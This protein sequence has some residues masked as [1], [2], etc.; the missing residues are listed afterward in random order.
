MNTATKKKLTIM[1]DS[2]VYE[3]IKNKVGSRRIGAYL[4]SLARPHVI[5]DTL[6]EGYKAMA[7]DK[8]YNNEASEWIEGT[9]DSVE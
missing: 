8:K 3:G 1:L 5:A 6:Q 7:L 9:L 2:Q 4:S